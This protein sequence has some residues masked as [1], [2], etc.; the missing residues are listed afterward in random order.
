MSNLCRNS[1]IV[2]VSLALITTFAIYLP[3]IFANIFMIVYIGLS[4]VGLGTVAL[5]NTGEYSCYNWT[6]SKESLNP[7]A[8]PMQHSNCLRLPQNEVS[9]FLIL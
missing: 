8:N 9:Y 6:P 7:K 1:L 2:F 4:I 5:T 3:V